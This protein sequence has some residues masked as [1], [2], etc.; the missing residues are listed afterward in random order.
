MAH[1]HDRDIAAAGQTLG[2]DPMALLSLAVQTQWPN[3]LLYVQDVADLVHAEGRMNCAHFISQQLVILCDLQVQNKP[4]WLD[5]NCA[6][7]LCMCCIA[8]TA[9]MMTLTILAIVTTI[10]LTI[11]ISITIS[12][13]II[14]AIIIMNDN[15]SNSNNSNTYNSNSS[16]SNNN[17]RNHNDNNNGNNHDSNVLQVL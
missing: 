13:L 4:V 14:T 9:V 17:N 12:I 1:K 11:M 5:T 15:N 10:I 7:Q 2:G 8:I 6:I 3:A 16:S